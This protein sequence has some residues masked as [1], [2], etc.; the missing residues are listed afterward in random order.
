MV[1]VNKSLP[2]LDRPHPEEEKKTNK[3]ARNEGFEGNNLLE[4]HQGKG[5]LISAIKLAWEVGMGSWHVLHNITL[6]GESMIVEIPRGVFRL[7][8]C[9][10]F[11][12]PQ[13]VKRMRNWLI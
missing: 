4:T 6:L 2:C 13:L 8:L 11:I 3:I 10:T 9:R 1:G 5:L 12:D 7:N